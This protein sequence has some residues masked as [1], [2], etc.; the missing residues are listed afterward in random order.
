MITRYVVDTIDEITGLVMDSQAPHSEMV[1][2]A[3]RARS[4]LILRETLPGVVKS[5][6]VVTVLI[7][8]IAAY[9][10]DFFI[11]FG[12]PEEAGSIGRHS[13]TALLGVILF[14]AS[15]ERLGGYKFD[16]LS[17]LRWQVMHIALVWFCMLS[18]FSLI[19]F[20]T[21]TSISYSRGWAIIWTCLTLGLLILQRAVLQLRIR[22]LMRKGAFSRSVVI[23]GAGEPGARLI[24][25]LGRTKADQ[26]VI[27]GVFD[28]RQTR[29]ALHEQTPRLLGKT[30]DLFEYIRHTPIDDIIIALPLSAEQRVKSIVGKLKVLPVDLRLSAEQLG[31]ACP[32][33]RLDHDFGVLILDL[34]ERPLKN[35]NGIAKWIEDKL[36]S[37]ILLILFS[38]IMLLISIAIKLDSSGPVLFYQRRYG[39]NNNL[40]TI[41]KFRTLRVEETDADARKLVTRNDNR[42]TRIGNFLRRFSLDELPQL[43]NV[44]KG[45]MSIVGPRPHPTLAKAGDQLYAEVVESYMARHRVKPGLTGWAQ[46]NGWRGQTQTVEKIQ[47]RVEHDMYYIDNWSIWFDLWIILKTTLTIFQ[48]ESAY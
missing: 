28:D 23:V 14:V 22:R 11:F 1:S 10:T 32:I 9:I 20:V 29:V 25:R 40:I 16:Q 7:C 27:L 26:V 8:A 5:I 2:P 48:Q 38:P 4:R 13:I 31:E 43:I 12:Y 21:K 19:A 18:V 15:L 46:I 36:L 45:E 17:H 6:D 44:I 3:P 42:V 24:E 33:R 37:A 39:Y 34:I 41:Y 47:K 30:D 35:W